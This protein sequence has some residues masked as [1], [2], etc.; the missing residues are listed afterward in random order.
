MR[1]D[2]SFKWN[3]PRQIL[4]LGTGVGWGEVTDKSIEL[5][6]ELSFREKCH[7]RGYNAQSFLI[8]ETLL[9]SIPEKNVFEIHYSSQAA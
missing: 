9:I 6:K 8:A 4:G 5:A 3:T 7:P 2:T 1:R